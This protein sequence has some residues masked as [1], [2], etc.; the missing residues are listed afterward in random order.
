[1]TLDIT[2]AIPTYNGAQRI[3]PVLERLR[4]QVNLESRHWEILV[5]D[6]NSTDQTA[7]IVRS[8][9]SEWTAPPSLR[10]CFVAQQGLAFARQRA[11]EESTSRYV[12]FL[13][14]D[15]LPAPDWVAAA[16]AFGD[17]HPQAGAFG[18]I[19]NPVYETAPPPEFERV[20]AFLVIRKH[21]QQPQLYEPEKLRLP[22]GA[23]LVVRSQAW[24]DS[25]PKQLIRIHRGGNDY[26]ISLHMHTAG[27]QIW[28]N[29]AMQIDHV[30]PAWRLERSY[31]LA[32]AHLYGLC[33]C[34][35]RMI[36][37]KPWQRP[38]LLLRSL[39][40]SSKRLVFH[41]IKYGRA[42][43]TDLGLAC[44]LAFFWGNWLSPF[45]YL[46]N[47]AHRW[48]AGFFNPDHQGIHLSRE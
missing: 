31:L 40:G 12:G 36:P 37:A 25:V 34:E 41:I 5:V 4:S 16:I 22:A 27:W 15:N 46:R 11:I 21:G 33:T 43:K 9:Q 44:E 10:Y 1:M 14:D 20:K 17:T 39:L 47:A 23:G 19:T 3:L 35:L 28:Y 30:I 8:L 7:D 2:V 24:L 18:G 29:P 26:E 42:V 32:I 13:D 45:F 6:N 38:F 48:L